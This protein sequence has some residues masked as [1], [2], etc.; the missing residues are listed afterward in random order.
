MEASPVRFR[1]IDLPWTLTRKER[2]RGEMKSYRRL[3]GGGPPYSAFTVHRSASGVRLL[4]WRQ[5]SKHE[6]RYLSN[7]ALLART[8]HGGDWYFPKYLL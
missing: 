8:A 7:Y 5:D 1:Y 4:R 3:L 2:K 6:G